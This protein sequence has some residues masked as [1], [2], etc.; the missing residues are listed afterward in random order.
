MKDR[1]IYESAIAKYGRAAQR[2]LAIEEMSELTKELC[3][4][5]RGLTDIESISEEIADVMIML[6]QLTIMFDCFDLVSEWLT[7][8]TERLAERVNND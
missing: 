1:E 6:K 7:C 4:W 3:K 2:M 8:K 5:D